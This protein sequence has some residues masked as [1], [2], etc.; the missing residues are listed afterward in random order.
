MIQNWFKGCLLVAACL[1]SLNTQAQTIFSPYTAQGLGDTGS[2]G[3][4]NNLGMAGM[5]VSYGTIWNLN[6][7]N[8]ALLTKNANFTTFQI[9]TA[10]DLRRLEDVNGTETNYQ[11]GFNYAIIGFPVY[12]DRLVVAAA[13]RPLTN[14][15]YQV[16]SFTPIGADDVVATNFEGQGGFSEAFLSAGVKLNENFSIGGQA[17]YIFGSIEE[18]RN[19]LFV[20]DTLGN[21]VQSN[22]VSPSDF[23]FKASALYTGKIGKETYLNLAGVYQFESDLDSDQLISLER[24]TVGGVAVDTVSYTEGEIT[25]PQFVWGSISFEKQYKWAVGVDYRYGNWNGFTSFNND[26]I[27]GTN[28][29]LNNSHLWILGGEIT[30]DINN[31]TSYFSR[32][33]YRA[34]VR[35]EQ[36][37]FTSNGKQVDDLGISF[38]LGLPIRNASFINLAVWAGRRGWDEGQLQENYLRMFLGFTFNDKW[39]IRRKFN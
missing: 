15:S 10:S 24:G 38:G 14:V 13:Y 37:Q 22:E 35:Y 6:I 18:L 23:Y 32:I 8:P 39:F 20:G 12:R 5:G 3:L 30:P 19:P 33:A 29:N 17:S 9:G 16:Q 26:D 27:T 4:T 1:L 34:G 2:S 36:T 25:Y 11:G 7:I 31:V 21:F 28:D